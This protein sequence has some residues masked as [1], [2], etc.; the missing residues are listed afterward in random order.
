M[1]HKEGRT[2]GPGKGTK[3]IMLEVTEDREHRHPWMSFGL[4]TG[5]HL[6]ISEIHL[7]LEGLDPSWR[8]PWCGGQVERCMH[9]S[10]RHRVPYSPEALALICF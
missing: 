2:L 4:V 10:K 7:G 6:E 9:S 3:G 1:G 5:N 8:C